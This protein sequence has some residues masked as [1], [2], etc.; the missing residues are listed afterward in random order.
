MEIYRIFIIGADEI[1][2]PWNTNSF[3]N[4]ALLFRSNN[5]GLFY[6]CAARL[7]LLSKLWPLD[8]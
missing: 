6:G 4:L 7:S 5:D 8:D 1:T 3:E 2:S